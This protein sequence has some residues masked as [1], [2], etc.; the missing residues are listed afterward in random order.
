MIR[1]KQPKETAIE[2]PQRVRNGCD[3]GAEAAIPVTYQ[4]MKPKITMSAPKVMW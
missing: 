3:F 2:G 1:S 4:I